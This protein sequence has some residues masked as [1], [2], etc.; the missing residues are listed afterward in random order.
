M[1]AEFKAAAG[2]WVFGTAMAFAGVAVSRLLAPGFGGRPHAA[3]ALA[4]QLIALG[5]LV[6]ILFGI[7]RRL[8]RATSAASP[9]ASP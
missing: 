3:V 9:T 4:G 6:V 8:R 7:R 1:S 2:H 5:G